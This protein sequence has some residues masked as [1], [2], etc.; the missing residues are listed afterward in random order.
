MG[1]TQV[2]PAPG[3]VMLTPRQTLFQGHARL[4]P[5][6]SGTSISAR[7]VMPFPFLKQGFQQKQKQNTGSV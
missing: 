3:S 5:N 2:V 7:Q 1:E 6:S 4:E